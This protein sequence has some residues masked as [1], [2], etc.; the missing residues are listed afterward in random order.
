M[1]KSLAELPLEILQLIVQDLISEHHRFVV[2]LA[3]TYNKIIYDACSETLK[4]RRSIPAN[5]RVTCDISYKEYK[6]GWARVYGEDIYYNI[7]SCFDLDGRLTWLDELACDIRDFDDLSEYEGDEDPVNV[8]GD[9]EDDDTPAIVRLS[10]EHRKTVDELI[11]QAQAVGCELPYPYI[12][13]LKRLYFYESLFGFLTDYDIIWR[14]EKPHLHR[15]HPR[16]GVTGYLVEFACSSH[17]ESV[18]ALYL[19]PGSTK[20]HAVVCSLGCSYDE[21][22]AEKDSSNDYSTIKD[23][24]GKPHKICNTIYDDTLEFFSFDFE[25]WLAGIMCYYSSL[26]NTSRWEEEH[27]PGTLR[28]E[29]FLEF[30]RKNPR[31]QHEIWSNE[32]DNEVLESMLQANAA[33]SER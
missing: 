16:E 24:K 23:V 9:H 12:K 7:G 14:L 2:P 27:P 6:P 26:R 1:A 25:T 13:F 31:I 28:R 3:Q 30:A 10:S 11:S 8:G 33:I 4:Y 21:E 22:E 20:S 5:R 17:G 19:D 15:V 32:L 29:K 18:I